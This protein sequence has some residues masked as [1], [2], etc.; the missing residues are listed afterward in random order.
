MPQTV[1]VPGVGQLQFPDGMSQSDMATAIQRNFPQIHQADA[2]S[3]SEFGAQGRRIMAAVDQANSETGKAGLGIGETALNLASGIG[4]SIVGGWRGLAALATG[5]SLDDAQKAI[6]DTQR[7]YT[8]QPRTGIGKL[9]SELAT[10]PLTAAKAGTSA[11]GGAI[12]ERINGEQGRIAGESIGNVLPDVAATFAGGRAAF[13]GRSPVAESKPA[14]ATAPAVN[15]NVPAYVRNGVKP[16]PETAGPPK[17]PVVVVPALPEV[18]PG[19][20]S[21]PL[22]SYAA[23]PIKSP[24]GELFEPIL[25]EVAT[26][27]SALDAYAG[28]PA[29][30]IRPAVPLNQFDDML[31][32]AGPGI[33]APKSPLEALAAGEDDTTASRLTAGLRD[34]SDIDAMLQQFGVSTPEPAAPLAIPAPTNLRTAEPIVAPM[35]PVEAVERAAGPAAPIDVG[36]R[37]PEPILGPAAPTGAVEHATA[38]A[39]PLDNSM[40]APE[41]IAGRP[42]ALAATEEPFVA[43]PERHVDP[44]RRNQHLQVLRDVGLDNIRESAVT[45]DAARAA[46]E[47]QHGKF[48]SEPAGQFWS[49]QFQRETDAMKGYAQRLVDD[50]KGRTGL[51][52]ESLERKG[53]DIA[54]PYDAARGYFEKAKENLYDIANK[55]A[56]ETNAPVKTEKLDAL[57]DDPDF[58][59]TLMAKDQQGLL[60]TI[61]SQYERFKALDPSGQMSVLNAERYRKWLNAV[62]SPDS[63][64]TLGKVKAALDEDVFKTAGEDVYAA[65]R[66]MHQLEKKTLDDPNGISKLMDSDP[67]TPINR[68]TPYE[69]IPNSLVKLSNEQFRHI[70]DTY[71]DLPP[72]LQPMAQ[73]AIATLKAHYAERLLSSG[74]ETA[75][76]NGRQL[77]NAGGVKKFAADNSAKLPMLFNAGELG[78]INTLLQAG[79]ILRVNPAYPGA[80]AQLANASKAGL[81][82]ALAG[83][84]GAGVGGAAGAVIAG[85]F[86]AGAGGLAGDAL[87]GQFSRLAGERKALAEAKKAIISEHMQAKPRSAVEEWEADA[88]R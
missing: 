5:G 35:L 51:D 10:V 25:P 79:D 88:R 23:A 44:A 76:G 40:A 15:Y 57:L 4:S 69:A 75:Y 78:R 64:G 59:A 9:G 1:N 54:A 74:A 14:I 84:L 58:K 72:E 56:E 55:R 21:T 50:T 77:W 39:A 62:W 52:G 60:N 3:T 42:A 2:S 81:M 30:P 8:Y 68:A 87:A 61:V 70:I 45:G 16:P 37:V 34:T 41:P 38:P 73:Q 20:A 19:A 11:I 32:E 47:F 26:K 82:S 67:H 53:R 46:R 86:G 36:L 71:R 6:E 24:Y 43:T 63:S 12:G 33:A 13:K 18:T 27:G 85:P 31:R 48:T 28:K 49:D 66:Q 7:D 80:A 65:A 17:P 29:G 22:E 83:K